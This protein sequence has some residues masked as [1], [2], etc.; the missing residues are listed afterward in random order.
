MLWISYADEIQVL[1]SDITGSRFSRIV[2]SDWTGF[3]ERNFS[4]T[5]YEEALNEVK[6]HSLNTNNLI[7]R[8]FL[9]YYFGL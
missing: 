7:S 4:K 5:L 9:N 2:Y 1:C 8:D 6:S 3:L